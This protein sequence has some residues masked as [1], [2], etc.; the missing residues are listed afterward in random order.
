M[1]LS[2]NGSGHVPFPPK[3]DPPPADTDNFMYYL[4]ILK[5]EIKNWRYIGTTEDLGNRFNEHNAG[6]VRSTKA[7]KPFKII[8]TEQF[9]DKTS[10][11]KRELFL[12]KNALARKEIFDKV[13]I[14]PIV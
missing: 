14:G 5:S 2:S 11:R 12:K 6:E 13:G 10:A 8:H 7:Y 4:Y 3:A 9:T 1:V